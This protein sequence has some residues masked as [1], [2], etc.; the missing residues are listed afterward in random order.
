MNNKTPRSLYRQ[1]LVVAYMNEKVRRDQ[2][3]RSMQLDVYN[4]QSCCYEM[5]SVDDAALNG[6]FDCLQYAVDHGG[7]WTEEAPANAVISG[8]FDMLRY[9]HE[10]GCPFDYRVP[11]RA[12]ILGRMDMLC[13]AFDKE[14]D[15]ERDL[16][17]LAAKYGRVDMM[18]YLHERDFPIEPEAQVLA[19][20]NNHLECLKYAR[21]HECPKNSCSNTYLRFLTRKNNCVACTNYLEDD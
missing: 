5:V 1:C 16:I 9:L 13:Y 21:E 11:R 3:P 19:A 15:F 2:L 20:A 10:K 17:T 12:V 8:N 14:C 4:V 7:Q 18:R 6:H